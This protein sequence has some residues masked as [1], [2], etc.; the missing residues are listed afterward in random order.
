MS[1]VMTASKGKE[2]EIRQGY[3]STGSIIMQLA[4]SSDEIFGISIISCMLMH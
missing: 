2:L 3:I 4:E 1:E